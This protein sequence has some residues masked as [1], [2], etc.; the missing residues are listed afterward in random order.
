MQLIFIPKLLATNIEFQCSTQAIRERLA[1]YCFV[2]LEAGC[3]PKGSV[4]KEK[5]QRVS[6]RRLEKYLRGASIKTTREALVQI[7]VIEVDGKFSF[8]VPDAKKAL[9]H[10]FTNA[11]REGEFI[12]FE[13][14]SKPAVKRFSKQK[15]WQNRSGEPS[16]RIRGNATETHLALFRLMNQLE[17]SNDSIRQVVESLP[18]EKRP[19]VYLAGTEF[20]QQRFFATIDDTGRLYTSLANL[21]KELRW[22]LTIQGEPLCEVDVRACQPLLLSVIVEPHV[23]TSECMAFR[24]LAETREIY[25]QFRDV[26]GLSMNEAKKAGLEFLCGP[27]PSKGAI[28]RVSEALQIG[29]RMNL[30]PKDIIH[31]WFRQSFPEINE[32]LIRSKSSARSTLKMNTWQRRAAKKKTAAY[33]VTSF[34]MQ[35]L[36]ASLIVDGV[37]KEFIQRFPG[38]FIGPIH[39]AVLCTKDLTQEVIEIMNGV[40]QKESLNPSIKIEVGGRVLREIHSCRNTIKHDVF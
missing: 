30:R 28:A 35:S 1:I 2:M 11:I 20:S 6:Q 39:D 7:G 27:S 10:R 21:K 8:R 22:L 15:D 18:L 34:E 32:F 17:L 3:S 31:L 5:W 33:G 24:R 16:I 4:G 23:S 40:F 14:K 19:Y 13:L 26:T 29:N 37:C 36:E 12:E 38:R 25:D 9:G